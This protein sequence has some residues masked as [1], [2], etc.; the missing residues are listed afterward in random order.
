MILAEDVISVYQY[1][2]ANDIQIWLT[3]GWGID[4]LLQVQTRPHKDLDFISLVDDIVRLQDLLSREGYSLKELWSENCW[5]MDSD[6]IK[7]PTAFVLQ[8]MVGRQIDVHAMRL[9]DRGN[10]IPAWSNEELIFKRENLAGEGSITG[11]AIPCIS[12][13]MQILCHKGYNLP[14]EQLRDLE[15]LRKKFG[16]EYFDEH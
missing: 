3:G 12:Y 2:S 5:V 9:D 7:T 13:K 15:K 8:D 14:S 6:G 11:V 10:G 16:V 1:L 4:A